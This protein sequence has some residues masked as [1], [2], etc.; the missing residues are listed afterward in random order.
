MT[1]SLSELLES[2]DNRRAKQQELINLYHLPVISLTLVMPGEEKR[3]QLTCKMAS[4]ATETIRKNFDGFIKAD[5]EY[6]LETGFEAFFVITIDKYQAKRIAC[7][8]EDNHP[9]GRLFDIDIIG[10]D[11]TPITREE[12]NLPPRKCLICNQE[13]HICMRNRTHDVA[14]ILEKIQ[15]ILSKPLS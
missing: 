12:I 5:S 9:W 14:E 2:K 1:V 15:I 10:D 7:S 13:A 4:Q 3:N 8:I 11:L 6:D